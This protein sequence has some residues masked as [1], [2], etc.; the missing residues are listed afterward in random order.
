MGN[1][2]VIGGVVR[3]IMKRRGVSDEKVE[4]EMREELNSEIAV[5]VM[6]ELSDEEMDEIEKNEMSDEEVVKFVEERVKNR[7]EIA[8]RVIDDY[9]KNNLGRK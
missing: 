6:S 2:D 9:V 1:N 5:A 4:N 7:G 8:K 3:G